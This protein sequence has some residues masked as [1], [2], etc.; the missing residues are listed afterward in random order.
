[1]DITK[2][3]YNVVLNRQKDPQEGSYTNYLLEAVRRRGSRDCYRSCQ[4]I[5]D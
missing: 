1:M 2:E 4:E 3:L 5:Q